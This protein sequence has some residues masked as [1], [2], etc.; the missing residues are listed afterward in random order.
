MYENKFCVIVPN[1]CCPITLTTLVIVSVGFELLLGSQ[2][3]SLFSSATDFRRV[4]GGEV[5]KEGSSP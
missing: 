3:R 2:T 5:K 1:E 4:E